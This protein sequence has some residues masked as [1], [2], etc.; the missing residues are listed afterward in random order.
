M[1]IPHTTSKAHEVGR[2]SF[3]SAPRIRTPRRPPLCSCLARRCGSTV[4]AAI[5]NAVGPARG[6]RRLMNNTRGG[7]LLGRACP[8]R[9]RRPGAG[10]AP[11]GAGLAETHM[12]RDFYQGACDEGGGVLAAALGWDEALD[13]AHD[14]AM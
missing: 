13:A 3:T 11:E 6:A 9:A 12:Y 8:R 2:R 4:V 14:A 1:R 10:A 5:P 7:L